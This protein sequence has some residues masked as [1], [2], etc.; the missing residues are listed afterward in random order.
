M[1]E[2]GSGGGPLYA[3]SSTVAYWPAPRTHLDAAL[4]C[5]CGL[6]FT[7]S[8]NCCTPGWFLSDSTES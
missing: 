3:V 1:K 4:A 2:S 6:S 5:P 7:H 8:V